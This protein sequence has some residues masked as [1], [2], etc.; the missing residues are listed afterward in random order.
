VLF[1]Q[2]CPSTH[3][4]VQNTLNVESRFAHFVKDNVFSYFVCPER[5][6]LTKHRSDLG[7]IHNRVERTIERF[8]I[9]VT[10]LDTPRNERILKNFCNVSRRSQREL[11]FRG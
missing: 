2:N 10:L 5:W 3:P 7:I 11:E 9:V 8:C 4:L 1:A 6:V